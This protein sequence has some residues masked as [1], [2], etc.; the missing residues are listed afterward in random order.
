MANFSDYYRNK[1]IDH[2][3]RDVDFTP[4]STIY[5]ALFTANT[6][7]QAN[8]P[9]A[10]VDATGYVRKAIV[11]DAAGSGDHDPG[12]SA[13]SAVY[14]W[15]PAEENWGTV[16]H[17]ALV[18]HLNNDDW[19]VDVNVLKWNLLEKDGEPA[20]KIIGKDDIFRLP[21]GNLELVVL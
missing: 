17:V 6:G 21:E 12:E 13:N 2:M 19:G 5:V 9:S 4:P 20:P 8:D 16:T 10:E 7:L 1:I 3:F 14:E 11:L 15:D 18:D